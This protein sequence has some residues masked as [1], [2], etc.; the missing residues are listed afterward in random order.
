MFAAG[1][2]VSPMN[3]TAI[4]LP[5]IDAFEGDGVAEFDGFDLGRDI[6]I[7][8]NKDRLTGRLF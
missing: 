4:R 1:V 2:V 8:G 7:V 6:N 3:H 5:L